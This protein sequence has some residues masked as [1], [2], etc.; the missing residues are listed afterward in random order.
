MILRRGLSLA[1]FRAFLLVTIIGFLSGCSDR[2]GNYASLTAADIGTRIQQSADFSKLKQGDTEK[3]LKLYHID[4]GEV[5]DFVLYT[6]A[7]NVKADELAVIKL[8]DS[9]EM[10]SVMNHIRQRVEEQTIKFKDYRPQENYLIEKH[11]LKSKGPFILF[12]V[13]SDADRMEKAFDDT[14]K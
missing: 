8:K 5:A 13:S 1:L 4:T 7:S 11:V 2:P 14:F 12:A 10:D 3:L 6:A 9:A